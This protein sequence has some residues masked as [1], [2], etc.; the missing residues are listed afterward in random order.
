VAVAFDSTA[1]HN[2]NNTGTGT[3]V[4]VTV[5]MVAGETGICCVA[6]KGGT[7]AKVSSISGGGTWTLL[8]Q[9]TNSTTERVEIWGT[10]AG[11][12]AT[13]STVTVN[14]SGAPSRTTAGVVQ[15][16]GVSNILYNSAIKAP[17]VASANPT[18]AISQT[19]ANSFAVAA[20][21]ISSATAPTSSAGNLRVG[22]GAGSGGTV[23]ALGV[24]DV[25]AAGPGLLTATVT[26]AS[27]IHAAACVELTDQAL[28]AVYLQSAPQFFQQ[29]SGSG[30]SWTASISGTGPFAAAL[31]ISVEGL[32][33]AITALTVSD[34]TGAGVTWVK[35]A[36]GTWGGTSGV[37]NWGRCQVWTAY[38]STTPTAGTVTAAITCSS[39]VSGSMELEIWQGAS[40][41]IGNT[42]SGG[43]TDSTTSASCADS[44]TSS[45]NNSVFTGAYIDGNAGT[46][47]TA[48]SSTTLG[49]DF[50]DSTQG[51]TFATGRAPA[52][53]TSGGSST[54]GPNKSNLFWGHAT[55]E[56]V[57]FTQMQDEDY[58]WPAPTAAKTSSYLQLG[59]DSDEVPTSGSSSL[60]PEEDSW[61]AAP[62][63]APPRGA[64]VA[65]D[66]EEVPA[67]A[68]LGQPEEDFAWPAPLASGPARPAVATT[69]AGVAAAWGADVQE[70]GGLFG[71]YD[72]DTP[73]SEPVLLAPPRPAVALTSPQISGR[74]LDDVQ[75]PG[76]LF[77]Q[78]D[79]DRAE[80]EPVVLGPP[81]TYVNFTSLS[82]ASRWLDDVQEPG[83]LFGQYD[84]DRAEPESLVLGPPRP[85]LS[86][87]PPGA[88]ARWSDDVQ[89]PA[90]SLFGQYDEDFAHP[91]QLASG[92]PRPA[93]TAASQ[94]AVSRWL[95]DVQDPLGS[96]LGQPDEDRTEPESLVLGPAR[97]YVTVASQPTVSRWLD[98][99]Q[100]PGGLFG[101]YDE[102]RVE[103]EPVYGPPRFSVA[104]ASQRVSSR[105]LDDAQELGGLFGQ[106][107][108][109]RA[110]LESLILGPARPSVASASPFIVTRWADDVQDPAGSLFGQYDEDLAPPW[111]PT[112]QRPHLALAPPQDDSLALGYLAD[113]SQSQWSAAPP[114]PRQTHQLPTAADGDF[115]PPSAASF[116]PDEEYGLA[117]GLT[118][119][120][121]YYYHS[122][123]D[124]DWVPAL[125]SPL[126]LVPPIRVQRRPPAKFAKSP[127]RLDLS[128]ASDAPALPAI[129]W[130][131]K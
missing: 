98:D 118:A 58:P 114:Q 126:P 90:G 91:G 111:L 51:T 77:G 28:P 43:A 110:E 63:L 41:N 46:N 131:K 105:W 125:P 94:P 107:D 112:G 99:V 60:V 6:V 7:S 113:E 100:E 70:P 36:E 45:A 87:P 30:K 3:S 96:P 74:W 66:P 47:F 80:L 8:A 27:Q 67:G 85:A 78:H 115:A 120:W 44:I 4:A 72:E 84:E 38:F 42:A 109:D 21:A 13:A 129:P 16:T 121:R 14:V 93:V 88:I 64:Q 83:G 52:P 79:E 122:A 53:S 37:T 86:A 50:I 95:D 15:Y 65:V 89:D 55:V 20:F 23:S 75:E 82:A 108:E 123:L 24:V 19:F 97:P 59:L 130:A 49:T 62:P 127:P 32:S 104:F 12:A 61:S 34:N 117:V 103:P 69:S 54:V 119:G 31:K 9:A 33:S 40:P 17:T 29:A 124:L 76:G 10:G 101:Q 92:P 128:L 71:Q 25:T 73:A 11:G 18:V 5:T 35:Q 81:R 56:L 57:P 48:Q 106:Y 102:D 1:G 2:G 22:V 26:E 39:N 116:S 68:L